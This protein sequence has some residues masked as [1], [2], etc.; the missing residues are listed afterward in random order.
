MLVLLKQ[1]FDGWSDE[2]SFKELV[3]SLRAI[4][5]NIEKY[6]PQSSMSSD[7][8]YSKQDLLDIIT[9]FIDKN[10]GGRKPISLQDIR[11]ALPIRQKPNEVQFLLNTLEESNVIRKTKGPSMKGIDVKPSSIYYYEINR[12]IEG[13]KI[14][15]KQPKIFISHS[16]AD[17]DIVTPLVELF[18]A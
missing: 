11:N 6:Y 7:K 18:E 5:K 12:V 15:I 4:E 9:K 17:V 16:S 13:E 2:S 1:K 10:S 14:M 8:G 3:R